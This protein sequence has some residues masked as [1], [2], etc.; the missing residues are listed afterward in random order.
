MAGIPQDLVSLKIQDESYS[1]ESKGL[2]DFLSLLQRNIEAR[3]SKISELEARINSLE[4][5]DN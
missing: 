5:G 1:L 2:R 3:D 4:S